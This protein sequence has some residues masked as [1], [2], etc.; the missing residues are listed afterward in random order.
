VPR[1]LA[2]FDLRAH[3]MPRPCRLSLGLAAAR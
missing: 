1:A 3:V 2:A